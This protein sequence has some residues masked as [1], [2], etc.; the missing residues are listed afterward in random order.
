[1]FFTKKLQLH[2]M[3]YVI[4]NMYFAYNMYYKQKKESDLK[5]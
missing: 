3:C 5:P 1:M 2:D 4:I